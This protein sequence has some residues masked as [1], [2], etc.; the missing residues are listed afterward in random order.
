MALGSIGGWFRRY[1]IVRS[2]MTSL[3]GQKDVISIS[4]KLRNSVLFSPNLQITPGGLNNGI[5]RDMKQVKIKEL[6]WTQQAHI[7]TEGIS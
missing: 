6:N 7:R 5:A 2:D 4:I 3:D 1:F